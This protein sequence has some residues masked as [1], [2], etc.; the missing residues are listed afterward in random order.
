MGDV[1]H[2]NSAERGQRE[3]TTR[4]VVVA[5]RP[6]FPPLSLLRAVHMVF[7]PKTLRPMNSPVSFC[8]L[9]QSPHL[10]HERLV[11][12]DYHLHENKT[13]KHHR[14][15]EHERTPIPPS[16]RCRSNWIG[17]LCG[18][19]QNFQATRFVSYGRSIPGNARSALFE[20]TAA[21]E[22]DH[23]HAPTRQQRDC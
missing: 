5:V 14:E 17:H 8:F 10:R 20:A 13:R 18:L 19:R 4:A 7:D 3:D 9:L 23:Q 21:Q 16:A 1:E 22:R 6:V 15:R 12:V 11:M 2:R